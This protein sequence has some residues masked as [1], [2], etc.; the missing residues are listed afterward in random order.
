MR[1][2]VLD[3]QDLNFSAD[4][5]GASA[6]AFGSWVRLSMY[7]ATHMTGGTIEGCKTWDTFKWSRA[8]G[9]DWAAVSACTEAK[10]AE[11]NGQD[12]EV[13]GYPTAQEAAYRSKSKGAEKSRS[14]RLCKSLKDKRDSDI[15]NDISSDNTSLRFSPGSISS[16]PAPAPGPQDL[17]A[18]PPEPRAKVSDA[19]HW[20][21]AEQYEPYVRLL[22]AAMCK[23]GPENWPQWKA[24][25]DHWGVAAVV[26]AAKGIPAPE[27]WPDRV[28]AVLNS[29]RGQ[30]NPGDVVQTIRM[31][32]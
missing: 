15:R 3:I 2:L 25:S 6:M 19:D 29:S 21:M 30:A 1:K 18:S 22:K 26:A 12:L 8:C 5:F 11:W 27:R 28:D 14:K 4:F 32:L 10:L 20:R 7:C 24:L 17:F 23:V 16:S 31:T 13:V 9:L